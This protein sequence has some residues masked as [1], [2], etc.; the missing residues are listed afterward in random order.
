MEP[1]V[2]IRKDRS[3]AAKGYAGWKDN[4][5]QKKH[6]KQSGAVPT[7]APSTGTKHH[8]DRTV[9]KKSPDRAHHYEVAVERAYRD[10]E[11]MVNQCTHCGKKKGFAYRVWTRPKPEWYL[12]MEA[13]WKKK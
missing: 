9:C 13:R 4:H 10:F 2:P 1:E 8:K 7:E 5:A 12:K 6:F 3:L 11:M